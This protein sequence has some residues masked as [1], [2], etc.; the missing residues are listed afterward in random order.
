M[1]IVKKQAY[2]N[3]FISY[4]GMAIG[5]INIVF[6]IPLVL[7]TQE[8]GFYN[9]LGS[10]AIL[11]SLI[12]SLGVTGIIGK[13]LP[14]YRTEDGK[15]HGFLH[16]T[17]MLSAIGFIGATVLFIALKPLILSAYVANGSLLL[18][19]YYYLVPAALFLVVFNFLEMT[20]RV[21]YKTIFSNFLFEVVQRLLTTGLL[22]ALY[23]KW[24]NYDGFIVYYISVSALI[25]VLLLISLALSKQFTYKVDDLKFK[26]IKKKEL[27][28]YGIYA[29]I[30][31]AVYVLLQKVDTV[32]LSSMVGDGEQGVYS[33]YFN[34]AVV[35][36][37]P[38]KALS[39]TTY[40]IVANA[41]KEKNMGSILDVYTKTSMIQMIIGFLLFVGIIINRDNLYALARNPEY[42]DPKYFG[43]FLVIGLGFLV[44]ITG[45]LNAYIISVSHKYRLITY[46]A[47]A[48][49]TLCIVL[50]YLLIPKIGS[51]GAAL[52][53]LVTISLYNFVNWLYIKY[54]FKMQPFNYK[55]LL[56]I[57][58]AVISYFAG[59]YIWKMPNVILDIA[60]RSGVTTVV[61]GLL[62]YWL[63]ISD[64]VNEKVDQTITKFFK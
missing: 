46:F 22:F 32:M 60:V 20:G 9:L 16:W 42:T 64:D 36:S 28:N 8:Y 1:G 25:A 14:V 6:L 52:A 48:S 21:M 55:N 59:A 19:Y 62:T 23:F 57:V 29:L 35:I 54:R 39:R 2:K 7:N 4:A 58:I 17:S 40:A 30:T 11:Y 12:A 50:N 33:W 49:T 31:S 13:Y 41:W 63:K 26:R 51:M 61:Y 18:K 44:D 47:I 34:I 10:M 37:V 15:H 3:T 5:Y 56:V 24:I 53:Y 45:G 43:L 27:I 38:G